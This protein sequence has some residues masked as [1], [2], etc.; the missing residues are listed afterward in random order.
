MH[1]VWPRLLPSSITSNTSLHSCPFDICLV[2]ARAV[3]V[4]AVHSPPT[5]LV[6]VISHQ[7]IRRNVIIVTG[8]LMQALGL[9]GAGGSA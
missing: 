3:V 7:L 5:A 9:R 4:D 2:I 1:S 6:F 8:R